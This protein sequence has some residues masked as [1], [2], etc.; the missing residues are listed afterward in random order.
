MAKHYTNEQKRLALIMFRMQNCIEHYLHN[1]STTYP[2]VT[3][4][5]GFTSLE[6]KRTMMIIYI[7]AVLQNENTK[8]LISFFDVLIN[9]IKNAKTEAELIE[10]TKPATTNFV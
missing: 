7:T 8:D 9:S 6:I 10:N 1:L 2:E 5:S 4:L 3:K